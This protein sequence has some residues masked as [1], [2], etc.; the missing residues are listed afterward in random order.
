VTRSGTPSDWPAVVV[1]SAAQMAAAMRARG[2]AGVVLLSAPGAAAYLGAPLWCAMLAEACRQA[3]GAVFVAALDCGGNPGLALAALRTKVRVVVMDRRS[4][5]F[6]A[7]AAAAAE[8]GAA[9]WTS[10]PP[11][12]DLAGLDLRQTGR[13]ARWLARP[14]R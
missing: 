4:P 14:P 11:A 13:F 5:G 7:V 6:A 8:A 9:L 10:R 2:A 1:H 12:I 3:P